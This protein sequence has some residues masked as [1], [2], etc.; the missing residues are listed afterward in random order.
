MEEVVKERR[1]APPIIQHSRR[2]PVNFSRAG[3]RTNFQCAI[4]G[5]AMN[6][7][8]TPAP[9]AP[10]NTGTSP[11]PSLNIGVTATPTAPPNIGAVPLSAAPIVA[12]AGALVTPSMWSAVLAFLILLGILVAGFVMLALYG[13]LAEL[14]GNPSRYRCNP[15]VMPFAANLGLDPKENFNYCV[16]NVFNAKAAEVFGPIYTL[17]TTFTSTLS[18]LVDAIMGIRQMF[19]TFVSTTNAFVRSVRDRLQAVLLSIRMSFMRMEQLMGRLYG[20]MYSVIWMGA[21]AM[22]AGFNIAD[23][24]LVNFMFEFCFAPDTPVHMADG[25][26]KPIADVAIGDHLAEG[27]TVTSTL[28]FDG[29]RTP[30][31]QIGDVVLSAQHYVLDAAGAYIQAAAHPAAVPVA[32]LPR[33][34][35]LN[36]TGHMFRV[37]TGTGLRVADYDE[38][39]GADVVEA[40]QRLASGALNGQRHSRATPHADY[41]LGLGADTAIRMA[42]GTYAAIDTIQIGDTVWNAGRV[43]GI[44]REAC[45][46]PVTYNGIQCAGAQLVFDAKRRAWLRAGTDADA[47]PIKSAV[48]YALITEHCKTLQVRAPGSTR[49]V[50]VRDYREVPLPDMEAPYAQALTA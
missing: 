32:S 26:R 44:V 30:M 6:N 4:R 39:D 16:T 22:T 8:P 9:S 50:F 29:A 48:V 23:N 35:C 45:A 2:E 27:V 43:L 11:V 7:D 28:T 47:R 40:A 49:D 46:A 31:V 18:V 14:A 33:L 25:T 15:F 13:N 12:A 1:S 19:G 37:G 34:T 3:Q 41:A 17:L 24:D 36:V 21:S 10:P 5:G 20:T 42:D 38:H